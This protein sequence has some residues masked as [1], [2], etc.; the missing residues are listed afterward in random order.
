MVVPETNTLEAFLIQ[1]GQPT[2]FGQA[3]LSPQPD[4][5][6]VLRIQ[7][8]TIISQELIEVFFD[9]QLILSLSDSSLGSGKVGIVTFG[10]GVFA[11]DNLRAMELLTSRPLSRPPAY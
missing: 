9:N 4:E 8:S 10:Q 3:T 6:H 2:K 7:R 11:F 1:D 5:W